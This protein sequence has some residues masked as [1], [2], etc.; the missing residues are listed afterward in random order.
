MARLS[1]RLSEQ[2]AVRCTVHPWSHLQPLRLKETQL[3]LRVSVGEL[4]FKFDR[5]LPQLAF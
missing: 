4:S 1:G 3:E 2:H 5:S